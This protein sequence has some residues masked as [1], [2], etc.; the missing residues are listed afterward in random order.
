MKWTT[1]NISA[2]ELQKR[3]NF[4]AMLIFNKIKEVKNLSNHR[5]TQNLAKQDLL[6]NVGSPV[7]H[8]KFQQQQQHHKSFE[9][10]IEGRTLDGWSTAK[11]E[12]NH[13][14][15]QKKKEKLLIVIDTLYHF[16]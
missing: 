4:K 9:M 5:N 1:S 8:S 13:N 15:N 6:Q 16:D 10:N 11:A 3:E 12:S 7:L 14:K 2:N